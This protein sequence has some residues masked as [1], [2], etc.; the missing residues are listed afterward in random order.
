MSET[1]KN[2]IVVSG[3]HLS[4]QNCNFY[5]NRLWC[6]PN[7]ATLVSM[8][9]HTFIIKKLQNVFLFVP[10]WEFQVPPNRFSTQHNRHLHRLKVYWFVY[11][12]SLSDLYFK[13]YSHHQNHHS[14]SSF[15]KTNN[16][17][18]VPRISQAPPNRFTLHRVC[19]CIGLSSLDWSIRIPSTVYTSKVT[20]ITKKRKSR[21]LSPS[22]TATTVP[23]EYIKLHQ[24]VLHRISHASVT[25]KAL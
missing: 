13:S 6:R 14:F 9:N 21:I 12:D 17:N 10:P 4:F 24:T 19:I 22:T 16:N 8:K 23:A 25:A 20:S 5:P 15:A 3:R 11:S 18:T 1:L 2:L 7:R